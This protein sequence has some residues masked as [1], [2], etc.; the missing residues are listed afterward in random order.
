MTNFGDLDYNTISLNKETEMFYDQAE[1]DFQ[2]SEYLALGM[3]LSEARL[4]V[5]QN[6]QRD[7]LEYSRWCEEAELETVE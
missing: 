4:L 2:V 5:R 6:E 1:F 3:T 7:A